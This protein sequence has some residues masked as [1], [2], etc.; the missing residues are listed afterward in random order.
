MVLFAPCIARLSSIDRTI[1]APLDP[2]VPS[3]SV[4]ICACTAADCCPH[5]RSMA[6][7]RMISSG[8]SEKTA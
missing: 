2:I 3:I 6:A 1:S 5:A 4:R 7:I 8:A